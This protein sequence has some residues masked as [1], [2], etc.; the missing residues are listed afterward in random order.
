[1][2]R[3]WPSGERDKN[4]GPLGRRTGGISGHLVG[5]RAISASLTPALDRV[6]L[7]N[8]ALAGLDFVS[9]PKC[10]VHFPRETANRECRCSTSRRPIA[11]KTAIQKHTGPPTRATFP[12]ALK[13]KDTLRFTVQDA[14]NHL[15]EGA[16]QSTRAVAWEPPQIRRHPSVYARRHPSVYARRREDLP[17]GVYSIHQLERLLRQHLKSEDTLR[18][19]LRR[20]PSVRALG[21]LRFGLSAVRVQPARKFSFRVR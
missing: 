10:R 7:Q 5:G 12:E 3:L 19:G 1:M 13:C 16:L 18:F 4:F 2:Y 21:L 6:R 15:W 11:Q 9:F 17:A 8:F 14:N 20:H